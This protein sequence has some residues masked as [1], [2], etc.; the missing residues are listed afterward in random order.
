MR[1]DTFFDLLRAGDVTEGRGN[2]ELV[3]AIVPLLEQLHALHEQGQVGPLDT[4]DL[5]LSVNGHL[6]FHASDA[7]PPTLAEDAVRALERDRT[8]T[9][10]EVVSRTREALDLDQNACIRNDIHPLGEPV[11]SPCWLS[12]YGSWEL[13]TGHHDALTDIFL[14]GLLFASLA[15]GLDFTEPPELQ[16]FISTR[17]RLTQLNERL[18]PVLARAIVRMTELDRHARVQD[19]GPLVARLKSYRDVDE[20]LDTDLDFESIEGFHTADRTSRRKLIQSVL[21]TRLYD[22]SRRNRLLH[23]KPTLQMLDLTMASVPT[24]LAVG[25]IAA[26]DLFLWDGP[27]GEAL[28]TGKSIR[29]DRY[30]R[31]EDSPW[32]KGILDRCRSGDRRSRTE[33]GFSSLRLVIAFLNWHDLKEDAEARIRSPLLLLPVELTLQRGVRNSYQLTPMSE[34]AE[35]NP[36]LRHVLDE[37]YGLKLP[38]QVDLGKSDVGM[39][40]EALQ[41]AIQRS[42]PAVTLHKLSRPQITLLRQTARRRTDSW[43]RRSRVSGRGLRNTL[44]V[45]YSYAKSNFRPLG[46]QLFLQ[47]VKP[48]PLS[49]EHALAN[50][51][52]PSETSQAPSAE[53]EIQVSQREVYE[54]TEAASGPYD[55]AVDLTHTTLGNFNYRKMSL[56]RD[57]DRMLEEDDGH[58]HP[59]FDTLFSLDARDVTA[60]DPE[61]AAL[62]LFTVV[63][64][65][66]SQ[67]AAVRWTRSGRSLII[68]GP[69]GTGKSQTITN[70]IADCAARGQ[71]VLFVCQKRAALDVVYH[72]LSQHGLN[73]LSVIIHDAQGDKK[74]FLNDLKAVY[75]DWTRPMVWPSVRSE[76]DALLERLKEPLSALTRFAEAMQAPVHGGARSLIEVFGDHL[77]QSEV[78]SLSRV[79]QEAVPAHESWAAHR[80]AIHQ[81]GRAL[82]AAGVS[83]VIAK[84]PL[85]HLGAPLLSE[86][87]P[88][89]ALQ[90]GLDRLDALRAEVQAAADQLE[91]GATA[92]QLHEALALADQVAPLLPHNLGLLDP[93]SGRSLLLTQAV[94]A[95]SEASRSLERAREGTLHW[96]EKLSPG[97]TST[98]LQQAE[99]LGN[100]FI[101]FCLFMPT[102]WQLRSL[103]N[104]RYTFSA[105]TVKP[106]W[107]QVLTGLSHEHSA[108]DALE[109]LQAAHRER[110]GHA[111][112]LSGLVETV[113]AIR[114]HPDRTPFQQRLVQAW[115]RDASAV[116]AILAARSSIAALRAEADRIFDRGG[117]LS[118]A[119]LTTRITETRG[120]VDLL[121]DVL[122]ALRQL[123][124]APA[125]VREAVRLLPLTPDEWDAAVSQAAI[126]R[127]LARNRPVA[128][129]GEEVL[130][131]HQIALAHGVHQ[132]QAL[133]ARWIRERVRERFRAHL[134]L[135]SRSAAELTKDE[136]A[137]KKSYNAGRRELEREFEKVMRHKSIRALSA[138]DS[139]GVVYD[140]KPIWL[141]SP[142][143]ISDTIP[144]DEDRFD[145]VIFDEASQIPLEEAVPA[146]YRAPQMIVVGDEKQLPPTNFFASSRTPDDTEMDAAL[147]EVHYDLDAESFLSHSARCLPSTMLMWHYRSRHEALIRFSNQAFYQ[148]QLRTVPDRR[149]TVERDP[150]RVTDPT[151]GQRH[152]AFVVDRPLSYHRLDDAPYA[153]RVNPGEAHYIAELVR[154]LLTDHPAHTLGIVAFSEAQQGEIERA[155]GGLAGKDP[156]FRRTLDAA[157]EREDDGQLVGLFVKNLENVQGD[158]RDIII[159][160]VCY[161]PDA[162]GKMRMNFGPI[163]KGGGEKRLNV[164]FSRAKRHMAVVSSIDPEQITNL[165]NDGA[166]CMKR[167]LQF[168]QAASVDDDITMN[169]VARA[170]RRQEVHRTPR[171]PVAEALGD[172]LE[173]CGLVVQRDVGTS[174]FQVDLAVGRDDEDTLSVAVWIDS[175]KTY[176]DFDPLEQHQVRPSVL[177]AFG[178]TVVTV[179]SKDW[180]ADPA[181]CVARV[182]HALDHPES[183]AFP[184]PPAIAEELAP[185]E[186]V[187]PEPGA[188]G[189]HGPIVLA[190]ATVVLTGSFQSFTRAEATERIRA[191]GGRV[192]TAVTRRTTV[193]VVGMRPGSKAQQARERGIPILDEAGLLALLEPPPASEVTAH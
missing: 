129:F 125:A 7:R 41:A 52:T 149:R 2:E 81:A 45:D 33:V 159:L 181:G 111:N 174:D 120:A 76:R 32:I 144:I 67:A 51:A 147:A 39:F 79:D 193:V 35:V 178:W 21:Q 127:T 104:Q 162:H 139:G 57:Y 15:V 121:P 82:T 22:L 72:R 124:A 47:H 190:S 114:Q 71:R 119:E 133:N 16:R 26:E 186:V 18:H 117:T 182:Q 63:P 156:L 61:R 64:A 113:H 20:R 91:P 95:E 73:E 142:L 8:G 17:H 27:G 184:P 58:E 171:N 192:A 103:L 98:A 83:P 97:D 34:L 48:E 175:P 66:P 169:Q 155:L 38:E 146:V 59:A 88:V 46:Q 14:A 50:A 13:E 138:A 177:R 163:N 189:E 123:Q 36:V 70:L 122:S 84:L 107:V 31:F 152:A 11:T 5:V 157:I 130:R 44:G 135:S 10:I 75:T 191:A 115:S 60:P 43:R 165:Y 53:P 42:E 54:H 176:A 136:K 29:L 141:M 90:A 86:A 23:F 168:A 112:A 167:Y 116:Q 74:A 28:S 164:V 126:E 56:V 118:P 30:L 1:D 102:W 85:R 94:A 96:Q 150:I 68:Q 134:D 100:L 158:E 173:E 4:V 49:L 6:W 92:R 69:P 93:S 12:G 110:F 132:L 40:H 25:S 166:H 9:G 131:G 80:D 77:R 105:H 143:S 172:A 145:V 78:P 185:E 153:K 65:D 37:T 151:D 108:H 101:L 3:R 161:G 99:R 148:G 179:L 160:S 87:Q 89:R 170:L 106:T 187:A 55:W 128:S 19:L 154:G 183:V 180:L 109:D 62:D 137:F 24:Q 140:L 188:P